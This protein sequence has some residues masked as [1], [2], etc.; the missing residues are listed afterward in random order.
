[1][2]VTKIQIPRIP[3]E[4]KTPIISQLVEIIEQQSVIIHKKGGQVFFWQTLSIVVY[5][6]ICPDLCALNTRLPIIM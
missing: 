4:Q 6:Q 3:K 1:M 5:G 2:R